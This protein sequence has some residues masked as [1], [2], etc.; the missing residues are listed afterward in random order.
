MAAG[1]GAV[2]SAWARLRRTPVWESWAR[3]RA[4][5]GSRCA[6]APGRSRRSA[7]GRRGVGG[8]PSGR[9]ERTAAPAAGPARRCGRRT[10]PG[11]TPGPAS[12]PGQ[13]R[14]RS[15][16]PAH[17]TRRP[18]R[19]CRR[20]RDARAWS[21]PV[22]GTSARPGRRFPYC[23]P[24]GRGDAG[25]DEHEGGPGPRGLTASGNAGAERAGEGSAAGAE[26]RTSCVKNARET[27]RGPL[28]G[29]V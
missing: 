23:R 25:V 18:S 15:A 21:S 26:G 10:A 12:G 17:P 29:A 13:G 22:P 9:P 24:E 8:R 28:T 1:N 19:R 5:S 2:S 11:T 6:A 16:R 14:G 3:T 27:V 7:A 20:G 4:R